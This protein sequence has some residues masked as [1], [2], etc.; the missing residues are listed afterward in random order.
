MDVIPDSPADHASVGPGMKLLAVNGRRWKPELVRTAIKEAKGGSPI[1]L[2]VENGDAFK[3]YRID[4]HDGERYPH[5]KRDS[6]KPDL[7]REIIK[8][9]VK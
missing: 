2:L 7:L 4:Y 3:T 9:R 1:E 5:L 8:P 6:G